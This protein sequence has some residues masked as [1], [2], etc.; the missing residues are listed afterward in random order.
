MH[1]PPYLVCT[2]GPTPTCRAHASLL[3]AD[4]STC[5]V[6]IFEKTHFPT[7]AELVALLLS[8][9]VNM[10]CPFISR[11]NMSEHDLQVCAD[12]VLQWCALTNQLNQIFVQRRNDNN[13]KDSYTGTLKVSYREL[14]L[15]SPADMHADKKENQL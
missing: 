3:L 9:Q 14:L 10:Q 1:Q 6:Q 7:C 5:T 4:L 11:S 8:E 12:C 2:D 15:P 13:A